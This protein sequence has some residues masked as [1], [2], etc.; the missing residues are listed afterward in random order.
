M[1]FSFTPQQQHVYDTVGAL[2]KEKFSARA[3]G[4]DQRTETPLANFRDLFEAGLLG[5]TISRELG[6]MGGGI[7]GEDP[8]LYLLAIEQTARY[9]LST[10]HSLHIHCHGAHLV[11]Q[12][13]TRSQRERILIPVLERGSLLNATGSEPGRTSR[14]QYVLLTAAERVDNGYIVNG[15]KNYASLADAVDFNIVFGGIRGAP[16]AEGHIG[17]MIPR[18]AAGLTIEEGSWNPLGMRAAVSPDLRLENCFVEDANVLGK[19]GQYIRDR[20][21]SKFH[22]SFAAQYL[23]GAESVFDYLVDYLPRRGTASD[24]YAQL[25]LGEIRIGTDSVRRLI[26]HAA[27]M[28]KQGDAQKAE[29]AS[30]IAKHRAIE[31]AVTVMDRGAQIAGSTLHENIDKTAATIGKFHLGQEFDTT[32]RL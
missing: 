6:G 30:L 8:L 24:G 14:G 28:W 26:Y 22:L 19:P 25:R 1:E 11:D 20:W 21:Q 2:G 31:N 29:L 4:Y 13:C 16:P 18:G 3:A 15:R 32:A 7:A 5:L 10:A 17:L 27:W 9:C 12:M 23:G